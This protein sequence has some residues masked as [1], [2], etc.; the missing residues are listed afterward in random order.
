MNEKTQLDVVLRL[1]DEL[2]GKLNTI[3]SSMGRVGDRFSREWSLISKAA[4]IAT[5]VIVGGTAAIGAFAIKAGFASARISE[6]EFVLGAVAKANGL[7]IEKAQETV[8]ELREF[9]IAHKQALEIT[10]LFMQSQLD[11]DDAIRLGNAAKD[12]AVIGAMDS[13]EATK[14]LIEATASQ[15]N[16][17][18][19]QFGIIKNLDDIYDEY[20][21]T[22]NKT[23]RDLTETEKKQAF[24]N[25]IFEQGEKV[26]GTYDAAME[27]VSKRYRSLT[28]RIIP[29]FIAQVGKA[30]EPSM[31]IIIDRISESI[32]TMSG[33]VS[34]NEEIFKQWGEVLAGKISEVIGKIEDWVESIGGTEGIKIK[35]LEMWDTIKNEVIP[36]IKKLILV[37][38]SIIKFIWEHKEAIAVAILVWEAFKI[39]ISIWET[40]SSVKLAITGITKVVAGSGGLTASMKGLAGF[41]FSPAGLVAALAAVALVI[42]TKAIKAFEDMQVWIDQYN[43][44]TEISKERVKGFKEHT[45]GRI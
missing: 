44:T 15:S 5:G 19:R 12:L 35:L 38:Q 2:S 10:N 41:I 1:K 9:N 13:S 25:T 31:I 37:V 18:L 30:F 14:V 34:N 4:K 28:G 23:G 45:G 26:A 3:N 43:E 21:L 42:T 7:E 24:L 27:S 8:K 40:Y 20:G 36:V 33:W 16:M 6:L 39:A 29:D 32:K 22:I 11:L 17:A